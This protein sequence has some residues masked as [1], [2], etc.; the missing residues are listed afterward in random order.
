MRF[1]KSRAAKP[2][3][4]QVQTWFDIVASIFIDAFLRLE[5]G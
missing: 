5:Y 2:F 3:Y 4:G 1:E